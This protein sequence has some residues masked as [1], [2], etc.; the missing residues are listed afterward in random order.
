[1]E[2]MRTPCTNFAEKPHRKKPRD[3]WEDE[4]ETN[5]GEHGVNPFKPKSSGKSLTPDKC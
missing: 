4:N 5:F 2:E 1:M 3:K